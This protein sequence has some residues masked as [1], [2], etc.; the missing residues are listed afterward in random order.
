M[1]AEKYLQTVRTLKFKIDK[2]EE[3][4]NAIHLEVSFGGMATDGIRVQSTR[5]DQLEEAA[6]KM[7]EKLHGIDMKLS[8]LRS[9]YIDR[10]IKAYDRIMKIEEGQCRRFLIDYYIDCKSIKELKREYGYSEESG[11]YQLKKRSVKKFEKSFK[12]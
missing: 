2:Y 12:Q 10:R 3:I 8:R 5:K 7:M 11:I 6:I 4:R 1:N 9:E